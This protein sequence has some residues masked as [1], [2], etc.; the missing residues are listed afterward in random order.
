M[1]LFL[2]TML[3]LECAVGFMHYNMAKSFDV[4]MMLLALCVLVTL[5]GGL[6]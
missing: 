3:A 1:C 4:P 5:I 2:A 6:P